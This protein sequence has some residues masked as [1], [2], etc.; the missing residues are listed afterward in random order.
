MGGPTKF[1]YPLSDEYTR[2]STR[3]LYVFHCLQNDIKHDGKSSL[4]VHNT[5]LKQ[6]YIQNGKKIAF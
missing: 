6:P 4:F 2:E 3:L 1:P 5:D